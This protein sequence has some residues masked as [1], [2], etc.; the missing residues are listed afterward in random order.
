MAPVSRRSFLAGLIAAP[1]IIQA[2]PAAAMPNEAE[3]AIGPWR[4]RWMGWK[5]VPNQLV[6]FGYWFAWHESDRDRYH[7]IASTFGRLERV[8]AFELIDTHRTDNHWPLSAHEPAERFER[9]KHLA[10]AELSKALRETAYSTW[11]EWSE[12][13]RPNGG[14]ELDFRC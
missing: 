11:I 10:Y 4:V 1:V 8:R 9:A 3:H 14:R 6:K 7:W 12:T 13:Y 2:A 5:E